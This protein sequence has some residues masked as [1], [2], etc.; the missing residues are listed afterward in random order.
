METLKKQEEKIIN[1]VKAMNELKD[2]FSENYCKLAVF[3]KEE[4]KET[5]GTNINRYFIKKRAVVSAD[6][7]E[8][9]EFVARKNK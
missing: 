7:I 9:W 1:L 4:D 5:K 3:T 6:G 2:Q 8:R